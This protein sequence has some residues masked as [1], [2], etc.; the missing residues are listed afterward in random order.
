MF[1]P[2]LHADFVPGNHVLQTNNVLLCHIMQ[3][4]LVGWGAAGFIRRAL[5]AALT[6]L[7]VMRF[8]RQVRQ[9]RHRVQGR[10]DRPRIRH[11]R[12]PRARA[13]GGRSVRCRDRALL[14]RAS[15]PARRTNPR[16]AARSTVGTAGHVA[17]RPGRVTT[18]CLL[19]VKSRRSRRR[20]IKAADGLITSSNLRL[21]GSPDLIE[22]LEGIEA[23]S[24]DPGVQLRR[25]TVVHRPPLGLRG[26]GR[27]LALVGFE[28]GI[29]LGICFGALH[30]THCSSVLTHD[31]VT[32]V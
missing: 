14:R 26:R 3:R 5:R 28:H 25:L 6:C 23:S 9:E 1:Q 24:V 4:N 19:P 17:V 21:D 15:A 29:P 7:L 2:S 13:P 16:R 27:E 22:R 12:D 32:E 10:G 11:Q 20:A 8:G 31:S 18:S 30:D